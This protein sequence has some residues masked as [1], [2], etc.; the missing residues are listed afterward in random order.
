V[1]VTKDD[2]ELWHAHP[3]T[4]A[5]RHALTILAERNKQ[6]WI[7]IS[8]LGG[9]TRVEVLADLRARYETA[10]DLSELTFEELEDALNEHDTAK[11]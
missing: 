9:E 8:W 4:E 11:P 1:T 10:Q 5:V 6:K 2:F 3:V 7:E